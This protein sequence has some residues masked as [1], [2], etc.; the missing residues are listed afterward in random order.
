MKLAFGFMSLLVGLL[1]LFNA[2][3]DGK[4]TSKPVFAA[5]TVSNVDVYDIEN[6]TSSTGENN[7][8]ASASF[9]PVNVAPVITAQVVLSTLE[10]T[11]L[12][13]VFSHLIVTDPDNA[14]PT[15]FTLTVQ[16]GTNYTRS[17]NTITPNSNFSGV[18]IVPVTVYDGTANS[19]V[20]NLNITVTPVNDAPVI[21][22][23]VPLSTPEATALTIQVE[24][25]TVTDPDN[26]T[27]TLSV[28]DGTNYT[29]SGNTITPNT[30]FT[31]TLSVPVTVNDGTTNSA[32]FNL[33]VTVGLAN[34]APVITGQVPLITLEEAALT[35]VLSHLIVTDPDNADP[36]DFTLTVQNSTNYTHSGNTITPN[37]NFN[38]VL[39]VPVTVNDGTANSP[40]FNLNITVTPV[41]DAPIITAQIPLSTPEATALTILV[42]NVTVTDPDNTAFTLSVQDGTNYTR[43]GN[44]IT[45]EANFNGTLTIPVTV[46]DGTASSPVFNLNVTVS[47]VSSGPVI[48]AQAPLNTPEETG[49]TLVVGNF[50]ITDPDNAIFTLTVQDGTNYTRSGN[51]I[52]PNGNFNGNLTVPVTV[53]DGTSNS[54]VFSAVVAVTPVNDAPVIIAQTPLSTPEATPLTLA[55]SNL[56]VADPDNATV[57][58]GVQDGTNYTRSEIPLHQT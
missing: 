24:N 37:A 44:T 12:T 9:S 19:P 50:T 49:L 29:R 27:L 36:T 7:T 11:A 40:V 21:T 20:F 51:T 55:V 57:T 5:N 6:G 48:T 30:N 31:G 58:L 2:A 33:S 8:M 3:A 1:P 56:T 23:Q 14:D 25:V 38:G 18:L 15:D 32:V 41:N 26:S 34:D 13:I 53:N 22:S 54:D 42:G 43:S 52:T 46:S 4:R 39:I 35:I 47:N 17:G 28:L 45:P 16:N 10:E